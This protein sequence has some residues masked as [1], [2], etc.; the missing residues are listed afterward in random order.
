MK[1]KRVVRRK[2]SMKG[3]GL[4]DFLGSVANGLGSTVNRG[5]SGL[6]GGARKKRVRRMKGRGD[7]PKP[8]LS[9]SNLNKALKDSQAISGLLNNPALGGLANTA[10][11][12]AS[13][14][15]YGKKRGRKKAI[16]TRPAGRV[17]MRGAGVN[18]LMGKA[19]GKP[20]FDTMLSPGG[21]NFNF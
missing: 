2:T 8:G 21:G 14:L 16:K 10:G 17:V 7:A 4:F 11:V 13:A 3:A 19:A 18:Y 5:L 6:F 15:G 1:R 9:L 20:V 12:V